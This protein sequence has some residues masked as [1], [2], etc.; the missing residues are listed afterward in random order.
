MDGASREKRVKLHMRSWIVI[1]AVL[2]VAGLGTSNAD[3]ITFDDVGLVH[4]SIVTT[5]IPG[6]TVSADNFNFD[7]DLAVAF[8][9]GETGTSDDDLEGPPWATGNLGNLDTLELGNVLI[10]SENA[11]GIGDGIADDPDDEGS[12]PAGQLIFDLDVA[13]SF[14]GFDLIDIEGVGDDD[15]PGQFATFFMGGAEVA[16]IEFAEFENGGAHDQGAL[17]GNNSVNRIAPIGVGL[18]D[19]LVISLGGSGAVDNL[20]LLPTPGALPL[21]AIGLGLL[22][23]ARRRGE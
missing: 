17:F 16:S 6:L 19:R 3:I 9:T 20:V 21:F 12:R 7:P 11:D 18:F 23:L 13:R 2:F 22:F 15:E 8:D 5:Q 4:G 10:I 14:V 1:I